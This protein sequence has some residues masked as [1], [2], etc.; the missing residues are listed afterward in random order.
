MAT[1]AE[2]LSLDI[3][4]QHAV[5]CLQASL[6]QEAERLFY[7]I[8]QAQPNHPDANYY[9]G[10]MMAQA[11]QPEAGLAYLKTALEA[12]PDHGRCRLGY[13]EMLIQVGQID[14]ARKSLT[15]GRQ[16]GLAGAEVEALAACLASKRK[17]AK[18]SGAVKRTSHT[19][20]PGNSPAS[21]DREINA[22]VALLN[23]GRYAEIDS[24]AR[25][26]IGRYPNCGLAWKVMGVSLQMQG[27]NA[28]TVLQKAAEFL[29]DDADAHYNLGNV[30]QILGQ[31]DKA[32]ASYRRTL[33]INPN[34]NQACNNLG[35][36]LTYL[37]QF[38]DAVGIYR[39]ALAINPRDAVVHNNL[40][41][42][43]VSL[44]QFDD[45]VASY[46]HAL[47]IKPDYAEAFYNLGGLQNNLGQ[48]DDAVT[49]YHRALEI[50]P[51]YA[52]AHSNL[53]V[54]LQDL[55]LLDEALARF[56]R[57]LEIKPDYADAYSNILFTLNYHPDKSSEEIF[58]AYRE[59]DKRFGLPLREKWRPHNNSCETNRRLKIGYVSPD[60]RRHSCRHFLEPLLAH[61]DKRSAVEVYAYAELV[62]EDEVTTRYRGYVD[63][64]VPTVGMA[65]EA[66]SERI[67]AD[68]IDILVDLA[69][70]TGHIA[71]SRLPT[72]ALK[73]APVSLS[74]LG[75]GYTTG[76]TAVD[77]LLT[78]LASAPEGSEGLFSESPWR[79]ET[80]GYVYRP[81]ED[82]G[83]VSHLPALARGHVT[84]GTL[85]RAVRINYRTIR[86]WSEILKRVEGSRLVIDSRNFRSVAMQDALAE[87]FAAHGVAR[88]RLEIGFH[89]PPWD[90]LRS[91]DIGLDCFPHNSGTTLFETLYM[92]VPFV[93]L[94]GRPSAG[95]LGSSILEG[96]GHP[97]LIARTEVEYV[98][99]AAALALDLPKL[100]TLRGGLR[101]KMETSPLMDEA[102]FARK[103]E[104]AYREMFEKWAGARIVGNK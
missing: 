25:L 76:L 82:M 103:V 28:L 64:W 61:H 58:V 77:Y 54:T 24:R 70:H 33:E 69:S 3:V 104:A 27:K 59:F 48:L 7:T 32:V 72:F 29:P 46:H 51:V 47:E 55:G 4:L 40:A 95:R 100:V 1:S 12:N 68:G 85:T 65:D 63:H 34:D 62:Q 84:F 6:L 16:R 66:L 15:Q 39:Q 52:E 73:P 71:K 78:D 80:P 49:S 98:E 20:P 89:S 92:G 9:L 74:W 60:F 36:A 31:T 99:I 101:E 83:Q 81:A 45:A 67:R 42:A 87:K 10:M 44:G 35:H 18:R 11:N 56:C 53:G 14:T 43:L 88:E 5:N 26:L 75:F 94:A 96:V 38:N 19:S 8:L 21:V 30:Q 90:V 57:A 97:S 91:L 22:L 2:T 50:N 17:G 102:G 86:V 41:N 79:L 37:G 93:T 13:I 23:A